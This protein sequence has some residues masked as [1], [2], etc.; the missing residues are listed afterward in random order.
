ME[1]PCAKKVAKECE[2][3]EEPK[4]CFWSKV[5]K[6]CKKGE[7]DKKFSCDAK[8]K[9]WCADSDDQDKCIE[10][11]TTWCKEMMNSPCAKKAGETCKKDDHPKKCFMKVLKKCDKSDSG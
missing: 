9:K 11:K 7:K 1:S 6:E 8:A 3:A 5:K 10:G 2:N 4:N